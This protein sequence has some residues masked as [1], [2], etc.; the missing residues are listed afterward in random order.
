MF[1]VIFV[2]L[3]SLMMVSTRR[4]HHPSKSPSWHVLLCVCA[5]PVSLNIWRWC[6]STFFPNL[7]RWTYPLYYIRMPWYINLEGSPTCGL[8]LM[9]SCLSFLC[10]SGLGLCSFSG[11]VCDLL[12]SLESRR[13]LSPKAHCL[14]SILFE[15]RDGHCLEDTTV[16]CCLSYPSGVA[17]FLGRYASW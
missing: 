7:V 12:P 3:N 1:D 2:T 17:P 13:G 10:M 14:K 11:L 15:K 5:V 9:L 4:V 16:T 8:L 6:V